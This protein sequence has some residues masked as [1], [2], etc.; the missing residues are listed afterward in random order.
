MLM[1]YLKVKGLVVDGVFM[2]YFEN[3]FIILNILLSLSHVSIV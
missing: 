2:S 1:S 3:E